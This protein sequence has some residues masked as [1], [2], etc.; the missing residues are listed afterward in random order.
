VSL[1]NLRDFVFNAE[2]SLNRW[3]VEARDSLIVDDNNKFNKEAATLLSARLSM[4]HM[5]ISKAAE[6][7]SPIAFDIGRVFWKASPD[8]KAFSLNE[9]SEEIFKNNQE[10][11]WWSEE[12]VKNIRTATILPAKTRFLQFSNL[13]PEEK[14][15]ALLLLSKIG[16]I[17]SELSESLEG[18]RKGLK[19]DHLPNRDMF[20]VELAD[21][22]IRILDLAGAAQIDLDRGVLYIINSEICDV[23]AMVHVGRECVEFN[24]SNTV[25]HIL[26]IAGAC[27]MDIES[28]VKEKLEYNKNRADHKMVNR[29]GFGGKSI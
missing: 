28:A 20:E 6:E 2:K 8:V 22:L 18:M 12:D 5:S 21:T 13:L 27:S 1:N 25:L 29:E 7:Y 16:L 26:S 23:P 15:G 11:G 4:C 3:T 9:L 14:K 17:H 10:V 24:L 19:D